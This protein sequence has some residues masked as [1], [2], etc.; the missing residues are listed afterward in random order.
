MAAG[1]GDRLGASVPKQLLDLGGRPLLQ[2]SV[3]RS[4]RTRPC[5]SSSW[6]CRPTGL[7]DAASSLGRRRDP[8]PVVGGGARRQDS[9]RRGRRSA[10]RSTSTWCWSTTRRGRLPIDALIDRVLDGRRRSAARPCRPCR[11]ATPS[12]AST[13]PARCVTATLPRD[14]IWLAQTPQGF[15][16]TCSRRRRA[17]RE[18]GV[19]ATDEAM[20]A[21]Q[22][23]HPVA[24]VDGRRAQREDHDAGR[25]APRRARALA[26][27]PRV[28]T[29]YDLHR[30]VD[31]RPL[32]LAG[33]V[34]PS[35]R[36]PAR[37]FRRRRGVPR[38]RRRDARRRRRGRHRPAL[39]Q[40]RSALEG[41]AGPRPAR[42]RRRD[43][44]AAR[45]AG[46]ER[47]RHG[48]SR[49]AEARAAHRRDSRARWPACS[50]STSIAS[51]SRARP[52]KAWT[53][54]A[55]ARRS[56]RTPWRCSSP[57][58]ARDADARAVCAES[59]RPPARRQRADGAVQL[60]A[61][62][63][64]TAA[65]SCCASRTPTPSDRRA[66]P[67]AAS[68]TTCAGWASTGTKGRTSAAR[69]RPYRQSERLDALSRRGRA[70]CSRAGRAYRCFCTPEQLEAERAAA[71]AAGLPPK[72]SGRCRAL[73]PAERG[74]PRRGGRGGRDPLRRAGRPRR[75]VPRPR[76]RRRHVQHRRHRRSGHRPI[77]RPARLQLRRR[78]RRRADGDHARDSRRGS[79]L[80]HAAAGADLRGAR[81]RRRRRSR[82]CRS[83]SGPITRRC[84]SGTARRA[85]RS[86]ASAGYLPEALVNYL[87]LLGWSPGEN[88]EMV[89]VAEMARRFDLDD[90]Q[91]Q[92]RGVRHRQAGLDEPALHEGGG[93]GAAS[94]ARRCRTSCAPGTSRTRD[95]TRRW[96]S[97]SRCCRWR[98][99]RSIGSRRFPSAWRSSS[100][101][102]PARAAD[103]RAQPSRT[104]P[105]GRRG[106]RRR[107][108]A[109]GPA[110]S[111]GVSRR[112]RRARASDRPQG[113]R[114]VSSDPRGADR[115][116]I[117]GPELDLAVP[118]I[119]R[120]A[121]L[122]AGQ[123]RWRRFARAPNARAQSAR[124]LER[125]D[126]RT[127]SRVT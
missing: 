119:D 23:G 70:I 61:R 29:G 89:P 43:R 39:S 97:S 76:P 117:P 66:S 48:R 6:C 56:P 8:C 107:S 100:T 114:A 105:R 17:R 21:E 30:L 124:L 118:A 71:L 13:R 69:T 42:A 101:G 37:P 24:I 18:R 79:H 10:V 92:R 26:A 32:V 49:A 4:T 54:W 60:A 35:D 74:T 31:G 59:D 72:Y 98:W 83:C 81:A 121:A 126:L 112:G 102:M 14:E 78:R 33:V 87:A 45:L 125:L 67:S 36:G 104:A 86:S 80:E 88:E 50:A 110:R 22:A 44:R 94:R 55:A 106:V 40:H 68:S 93:A 3:R 64:A 63:R 19:D 95:R 16:A 25:S 5:P 84:R 103:A 108:R 11:R 12:S 53:R 1:R 20:L 90:G 51:A 73:D 57:G 47:R 99:G 27:A 75:D 65:R 9:V 15:R 46:R 120:G 52:T 111:R 38:A 41:R 34:I 7:A 96:R 82:I 2:H 85:S 115:P 127:R 122:P 28:G 116:P 58:A 113:P 109:A 77:G 123:R 91:P 62:A